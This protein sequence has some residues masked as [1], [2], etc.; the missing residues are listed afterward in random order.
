VRKSRRGS[1]SDAAPTAPNNN[2]AW[3]YQSTY[4]PDAAAAVADPA[5]ATP[6]APPAAAWPPPPPPPRPAEDAWPPPPPPPSPYGPI[7]P[8][9]GPPFASPPNSWQSPPARTSVPLAVILVVAL[10]VVAVGVGAF[11]VVRRLNPPT[12]LPEHIGTLSVLNQPG[13]KTESKVLVA[14]MNAAGFKHTTAKVYTADGLTQAASALTADIPANLRGQA[15]IEIN[16][17]TGFANGFSQGTSAA[18]ATAADPG[19]NGGYM[20]CGLRPGS[21]V[22]LSFCAWSDGKTMTEVND[23][24]GTVDDAHT[25][26][27]EIRAANGY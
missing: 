8:P 5:L 3:M 18:P 13:A 1:S 12:S 22:N 23:T 25:L 17:V 14:Q 10:V 16:V 15:D 26:A 19:P 2:F 9:G 6:P 24:H 20:A 27:L 21:L 11:A 7:A 4:A